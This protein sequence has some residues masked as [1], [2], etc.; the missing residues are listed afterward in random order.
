[1]N[2]LKAEKRDMNTKAKKLRRE[3]YVTGNVFGKK[4]EGSI[5]VKIGVKDAQELLKTSNKGSQ[6]MLNV[7]GSSM[8]V[9][10]KEIDYDS[11]KHQI[12]EMD[13]QALVSDEKV[14]SVAEIIL[15]NHEMVQNGVLQ[16]QLEEISYRA[17]PADLV[18]K[19]EID[20]SSLKTG[21]SIKVKDLD[22]ASNDKVDLLT[23]PEATIVTVTEVHNV[24][25]ET[26]SDEGEASAEA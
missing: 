3:G 4:I 14:H 1:M 11:M 24:V 12:L 17:L 7:D 19:I 20:V 18:E 10:I 25:P 5:P 26:E 9:L 2:T 22:I 23:D 21:D 13:F 8:D 6:I 15:R 16:Q